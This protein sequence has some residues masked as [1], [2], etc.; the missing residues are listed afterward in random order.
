[1]LAEM[2]HVVP[3][4]LHRVAAAASVSHGLRRLGARQAVR[5]FANAKLQ[6]R[7]FQRQF[8]TNKER[9]AEEA[10]DASGQSSTQRRTWGDK[11]VILGITMR[12]AAM[13]PRLA[14]AA[15]LLRF[16]GTPAMVAGT[17]VTIYEIGGWPLLL[18]IP[19][20]AAG[21]FAAGQVAD[22][23]FGE[24]LRTEIVQDVRAECLNIPAGA[25]EALQAAPLHQYETNRVRL[26]VLCPGESSSGQQWK[27][28]V[29]GTRENMSQPWSVTTL[30]VS[31][32]VVEEHSLA[33]GALPPQTRSWDRD[34][35]PM[36]WKSV[37]Q[38]P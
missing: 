12:G 34:A 25:I 4:T 33:Q 2:G 19:T 27:I 14:P 29:Y 6:H 23:S 24:R 21:L 8:S 11:I 9:P 38:K 13:L 35:A 16:A 3:C 32:G 7:G 26:E 37:W 20:T 22:A 15:R 18:G 5:Q 17:V 31:C 30:Q 36:R 1:M 28:V 10:T